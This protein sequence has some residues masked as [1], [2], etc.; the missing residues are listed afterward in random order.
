MKSRS[1]FNKL[2]RDIT[3]Y[4][5]DMDLSYADIINLCEANDSVDKTVCADESFWI[6]KL[7]RDFP[8][9]YEHF[10]NANFEE[11]RV[12]DVTAARS[13]LL[14][15][16]LYKLQNIKNKLQQPGFSLEYSLR[17]LYDKTEIHLDN[18]D[19]KLP[20]LLT[21]IEYMVNLKTLDLGYNK[22]T[23]LPKEIFNLTNLQLLHLEYNQLTE[24]PKEIGNLTNLKFFSIKNNK[25]DKLPAEIK[26]LIKLQELLL[27]NNR[28]TELPK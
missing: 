19:I 5:V 20:E 14:Y 11:I 23:V 24:L 1:L 16:L 26:T 6:R 17:E 3:Q 8:N 4:I 9:D 18:Y 25:L 2:P 12:D 27:S 7:K 28:L 21:E 15:T 13:L 22:L 10:Q